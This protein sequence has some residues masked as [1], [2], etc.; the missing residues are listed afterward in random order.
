MGRV[1]HRIPV[2]YSST[3]VFLSSLEGGT[4]L[5]VTLVGQTFTPELPWGPRLPE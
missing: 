1:V 4:P 5:G 2:P 3:V